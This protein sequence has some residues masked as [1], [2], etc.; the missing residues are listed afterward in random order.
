MS[1]V[2]ITGTDT[3]VGKTM[4][5]GCLAK[6]LS[7]QGI[8]VGIQKWASTGNGLRSD[9]V[10][11]CMEMIGKQ[12]ETAQHTS[13]IAPYC[14]KLP[15]SPHLA[16]E[17]EGC[18]VDTDRI[19]KAFHKLSSKHD[20]L[21]VEGVGGVMVPLNRRHLLIDLVAELCIPTLI[22]ARTS[23]GTINHTL[24]TIEALRIR[25]IEILA[26]ILN[27]LCSEEEIIANDNV[28]VIGS[29][30]QVDVIGMLPYGDL[31]DVFRAFGPI[32]ERILYKLGRQTQ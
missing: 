30:G 18:E 9:D 13:L 1:A 5:S 21:L 2:F 26:V 14:F 25:K 28:R 6:H 19:V 8:D 16:A 22:V 29:L 17:V 32:G 24:L 4:V 20:I 31:N 23:I 11:F 27:S 15:A 3:G 7:L 12:T 10:D